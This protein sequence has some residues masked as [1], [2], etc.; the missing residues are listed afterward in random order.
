MHEQRRGTMHS[1]WRT[2][3][4][5]IVVALSI[6]L[7]A[8]IAHLSAQANDP[9]MGTWKL[10]LAKSKYSPGPAPQGLTL[11]VE[12]SG[13]GEKVTAEFVNADATRTTTRYTANFDGKD[14]PLTGSA[15]ADTVSLKRVDARTTDRT[16]KKG[17]KVV[18]TLRRVVSKDGKTMTVTT[19]GT[20]A[21]GQAVNNVVVFDK[22]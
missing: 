20:N 21:Q 10:N 22:Q 13:Q 6:V 16:D 14:H 9:R 2:L 3:T 1:R 12:P 8:D 11:K 19:K 18:Q 4:L 5:G 15:I 7:V 17:G